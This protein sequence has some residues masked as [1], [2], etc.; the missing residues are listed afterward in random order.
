MGSDC[1]KSSYDREGDFQVRDF[2]HFC[3][4][5]NVKD[6]VKIARLNGYSV[7]K[8]RYIERGLQTEEFID[9]RINFYTYKYNDNIIEYA[10]VG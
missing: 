8:I 1:F 7:R 6:V 4:G 10:T 9:D 3:I 2:V 5:K